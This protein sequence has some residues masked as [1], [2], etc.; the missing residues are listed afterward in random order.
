MHI[1]AGHAEIFLLEGV[2]DRG[3]DGEQRGEHHRRQSD[4]QHRNQV[5]GARGAQPFER[6][7]A[8]TGSMGNFHA[9][10]PLS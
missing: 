2:V 8:D 7:V 1:P 4:G 10:A 6:K 9:A 3:G 5:A